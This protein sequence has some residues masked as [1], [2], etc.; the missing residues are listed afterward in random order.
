[1]DGGIFL[2]IIDLVAVKEEEEE[3]KQSVICQQIKRKKEAEPTL[4]LIW[5]I[6]AGLAAQF[7]RIKYLRR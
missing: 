6:C 1:M 2:A 4:L 5:S 7:G 3:E